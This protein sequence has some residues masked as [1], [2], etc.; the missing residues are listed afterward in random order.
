MKYRLENV[1]KNEAEGKLENVNNRNDGHS[2]LEDINRND[3]KGKLKD[4]NKHEDTDR[5]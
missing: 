5:L 4:V 2:R 1:N 3:T